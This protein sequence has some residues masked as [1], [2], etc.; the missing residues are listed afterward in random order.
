[1]AGKTSTG[2]AGMSS[3]P[4]TVFGIRHHGPGSALSLCRALH[5]LRPDILL[6]EGPP[7]A[8]EL[9]HWAADPDLKPPVALLLYQ[10]EQPQQAAC[11][12][13]A[14]FSPEWQALRFGLQQD[15][16]VRFMDLPQA[17]QLAL[18]A[19]PPPPGA[20]GDAPPPPAKEP[21]THLAEAAGYA[22]GERWWEQ[23]V[24]QRHGDQDVFAGVLEMMT[25]LR[26]ELEAGDFIPATPYEAQREA[27]MRQTI[28]AARA[29]GFENIAVVCGAWHAPALLSMPP[30]A[31]DAR[32]LKGLPRVKICAAWVPWSYGRLSW[33]S[34]YGA[35]IESPGWYETLW[36]AGKLG[37]SPTATTIRWLSQ[38]AGL[39]RS[40]DL[41][42]SS[43]H[44]IEAVRLAETLA[45]LRGQCLPGL[46]EMNQA[47]RTVFCF[48]DDLPLRLIRQKL[49][50]GERLGQVPAASPM[51][52]LQADLTRQ[53]KRLRL[54]AEAFQR[55]L[56]LDLRN[57][58]D[59]QRSHLLHR[60]RLLRIEW[61]QQPQYKTAR[62]ST[63]HE[64]WLLQWL[65]DLAVMVIEASLWGNSVASAAAAYVEHLAARAVD[66][67]T[68]TVLIQTVLLADLPDALQTVV[69]RLGA[70]A[71]LASD[72][73]QLMEA[74][75]D[76]AEAIRYGTVRQ[77]DVQMLSRV[78]DGLLARI[79][80][81]L[82]AACASLNDDAARAMF[83]RLL[84]VQQSID[85]LENQEYRQAWQKALLG[86]AD[87]HG[88]HG[89]LAGRVCAILLDQKCFTP[90]EAARRLGLALSGASEPAGAAA[91]VEGFLKGQGALLLHDDALW[92]LLDDWIAGLPPE[93]FQQ[94]LPALRRTFSTFTYPER[95]MLGARARHGAQVVTGP[96]PD[97]GDFDLASAQAALPLLAQL[98]GCPPQEE[99][100]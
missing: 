75:P 85:L 80:I 69:E 94:L 24:E 20:E 11:Y 23:L 64:Y 78:L 100:K 43:A 77:T 48:G 19:A 61:G 36:Q 28:R 54:P 37:L 29:E 31:Q 16:P 62:N 63:F 56:D 95:R 14:E 34:G 40:E 81:G 10:P 57:A 55:Q 18:N 5:A 52:P 65:P 8:Q 3:K 49:I 4:V 30:A 50:V 86:L 2:P 45:S 98:L 22:D 82:P 76:L 33:E 99:E 74:L 21:L 6:I 27:Y 91:W 25:T 9:L 89:L 32:L 83:P 73:G 70:L 92:A 51:T 38:V 7:D 93:T 12:P 84:G 13:F 68:L 60:L 67:P 44:I 90:Q 88:L 97:T 15:I 42:A 96:A 35:G 53:Q 47:A 72:A 26:N 17:H 71:A 1:M 39:L 58:T 66:L 59:L 87:Q 46:N 79:C 41:D